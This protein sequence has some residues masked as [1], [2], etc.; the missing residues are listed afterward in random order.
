MKVR[1]VCVFICREIVVKFNGT[2]VLTLEEL[3]ILFAEA[4]PINVS[5]RLV[6]L[7]ICGDVVWLTGNLVHCGSVYFKIQNI[8]Y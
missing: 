7:T 4:C 1:L 2:R 5:E 3:C 8:N 6:I